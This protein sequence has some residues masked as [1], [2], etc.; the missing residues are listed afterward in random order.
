MFKSVNGK[1]VA[2]ALSALAL[3][4]P[5]N[6]SANEIALTFEA[7]GFTILG[8]FAGF[9][10]NAYIVKTSNGEVNVPVEMVTCEGADCIVLLQASDTDS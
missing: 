10:K 2:I 4:A 1:F 6:V 5:T 8:E 7:H 3:T 9:Q